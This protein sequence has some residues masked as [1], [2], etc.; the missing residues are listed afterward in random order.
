MDQRKVDSTRVLASL[1]LFGIGVLRKL[2]YK[3]FK[4]GG[5]LF[6]LVPQA[7]IFFVQ[8]FIFFDIVTELEL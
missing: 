2:H 8:L 6:L 5:Q 1:H 7:F 4:F 3:F